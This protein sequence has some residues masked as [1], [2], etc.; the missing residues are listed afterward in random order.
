MTNA[1]ADFLAAMAAHSRE[2]C[3]IA[4]KQTP[5]D[6]LRAAATS[7]PPP[8]PLTLNTFDL[9]AEIKPTSPAEG[10][11]VAQLAELGSSPLSDTLTIRAR[12]YESAGAAAISILTEPSRFHGSLDLL[13]HIAASA[14]IPVMRKDFLIDPYQVV[15]ARAAGASGV[16][17]I[18]RILD[19]QT[20][21]AML[22]EARNL[23]MFTLTEA[24]DQQD[25]ARI[26]AAL[27]R[28]ES[29]PVRAPDEVRGSSSPPPPPPSPSSPQSHLVG[30]NC[31]D[32]S[33]LHINPARF[34]ELANHFPPNHPCVA[35]SGIATPDD[36][37]HIAQLNY[38]LALVGTS[39]MRAEYP[40]QAARAI[41]NAGR[42][43]RA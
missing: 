20:L 25:L 7:A 17:L 8:I 41:I 38:N 6:Q 42:E 4:S 27:T 16:L 3:A 37:A 31:R 15:E 21:D 40:E 24:F 22:A 18:A 35:E 32:L 36:A 29:A 9:I 26:T 13:A 28:A 12:A 39:L 33:T 34:I 23:D 2:R 14:T 30:L 19:D 1:P 11:L 10:P 5:I 43:A